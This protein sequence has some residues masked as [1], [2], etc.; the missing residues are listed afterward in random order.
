MVNETKRG[1][2]DSAKEGTV[3]DSA[4][5]GTVPEGDAVKGDS[6]R[7]QLQALFERDWHSQYAK[8]LE[9]FV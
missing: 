1:V 5:E 4:T 7:Q 8:P 6:A 2:P 3:P 9:E